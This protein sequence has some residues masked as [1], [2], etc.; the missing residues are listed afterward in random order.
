MAP[1][2]AVHCHG[3]AREAAVAAAVVV[4]V[5]TDLVRCPHCVRGC[6]LLLLQASQAVESTPLTLL[7]P[8]LVG[9]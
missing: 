3:A 1:A 8:V 7:D 2:A 4:A 9:P 5:V 6:L